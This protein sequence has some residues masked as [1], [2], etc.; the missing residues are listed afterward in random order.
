MCYGAY[1]AFTDVNGYG[2]SECCNEWGGG[3]DYS[4]SIYNG[5]FNIQRASAAAHWNSAAMDSVQASPCIPPGYV[6]NIS[7][8]FSVAM[9]TL[10]DLSCEVEF[11]PGCCSKD[12]IAAL[13]PLVVFA[14][15]N[16]P[17]FD[18]WEKCSNWTCQRVK[19]NVRWWM[20]PSPPL[21]N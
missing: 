19:E 17:Q 16:V 12:F 4:G 20:E 14:S 6:L 9:V 1:M 5:Y 2:T 18:G 10:H 13:Y 11:M 21:S 15:G 7:A 8:V 3:H